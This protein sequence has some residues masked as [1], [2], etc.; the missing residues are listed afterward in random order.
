MTASQAI[1][2]I[3]EKRKNSVQMKDQ[4]GA[5]K[6][7]E[8]YLMPLRIIYSKVAFDSL[9]QKLSAM[10]N[11]SRMKDYKDYLES[12]FD[13]SFTLSIFLNRQRLLLHGAERKMLKY[14]PKVRKAFKTIYELNKHE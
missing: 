4:I 9:Q 13:A 10:S 8:N 1:H 6:E 7:F 11:T 2:F 5:I 12:K 14:L 3:R